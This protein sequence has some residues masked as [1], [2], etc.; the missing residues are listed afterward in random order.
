[1]DDV[2]R[3]GVMM[4]LE[5]PFKRHVS[6]YA[7]VL[8]YEKKHPN[9]KVVVDEWADRAVPSKRGGIAP[10]D[11]VLGRIGKSGAERFS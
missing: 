11:G 5:Q 6:I 9:F 1:M 7:G 8:D 3:I 10:Y 4:Q 2:K